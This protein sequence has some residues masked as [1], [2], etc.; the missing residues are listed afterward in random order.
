MTADDLKEQVLSALRPVLEKIEET[1]AYGQLKDRFDGLSTTG[2]KG[3]IG[4]LI[5]LSFLIVLS[6]PYGW[7]SDTATTVEEFD[8]RRQTLRDL[9]KVSRE[10]GDIPNIPTPPPVESLR[11]DLENRLR[12]FD[13]LP[14]QIGN[15]M[16]TAGSTSRLIP[17]ERAAGGITAVL[18]KLN[19]DQIVSVGS[20]LSSLNPSVKL[21]GLRVEASP[22][23]QGYFDVTF[24]LT[25]LKVP[26]LSAPAE[27][28]PGGRR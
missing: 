3:V 13:V 1:P 5:A 9:F 4:G 17:A 2:Q 23:E 20:A 6:V 12:G 27:P 25:S 21:T 11:M 15:I 16:V 14:E 28:A 8:S 22:D 7:Y 10:L 18:K 26:D 24:K 19:L